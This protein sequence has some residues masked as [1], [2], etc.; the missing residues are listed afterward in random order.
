V[1]HLAGTRAR[2]VLRVRRNVLGVLPILTNTR[3]SSIR[4]L[5]QIRSDADRSSRAF[6][7]TPLVTQ[8]LRVLSK[9]TSV[10]GSLP[11]RP[12]GAGLL[13]RRVAVRGVEA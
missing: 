7:L 4:S 8:R 13:N 12:L 6:E 2:T 10:T 1:E 11:D 3:A 9:V 5:I